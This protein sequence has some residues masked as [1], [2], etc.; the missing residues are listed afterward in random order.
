MGRDFN[1]ICCNTKIT[2]F[3]LGSVSKSHFYMSKDRKVNLGLLP[4]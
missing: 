3:N 2:G 1:P 4:E